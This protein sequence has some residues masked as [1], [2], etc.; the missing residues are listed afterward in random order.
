MF[1]KDFRIE[2][3]LLLGGTFG[4][5]NLHYAIRVQCLAWLETRRWRLIETRL[6][7]V[8]S[9]WS[10][11][12]IKMVWKREVWLRGQPCFA[13]TVQCTDGF[14]LTIY[15][16]PA[17]CQAKSRFNV[18]KI[19]HIPQ[20]VQTVQTVVLSAGGCRHSPGEVAISWAQRKS[21]WDLVYAESTKKI[22]RHLYFPSYLCEKDPIAVSF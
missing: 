21:A 17:T 19:F 20:E 18:L 12:N 9:T 7:P 13:S 4:I 5:E 11:G 16:E 2:E 8:S 3:V 14:Q 6:W 15:S 22:S 1:A 10:D